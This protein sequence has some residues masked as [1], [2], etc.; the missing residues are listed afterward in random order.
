MQPIQMTKAEYEAKYGAKVPIAVSSSPIQMTR[1]EYEAKYS[2][3]P[4]QAQPQGYSFLDPMQKQ[5]DQMKQEGAEDP[6]VLSGALKYGA[7]RMGDLGVSALKLLNT[8][9]P[10]AYVGQ[11]IAK[12]VLPAGLPANYNP[13]TG[14]QATAGAAQTALAFSGIGTK[15]TGSVLKN[16]GKMGATGY[17]FDVLGNLA[18]GE[19]GAKTLVPGIGTAVGVGLPLVGPLVRGAMKLPGDIKNVVMNK[20]APS[21]EI[22][23]SKVDKQI[24][25]IFKGTTA[26]SAKVAESAFKVKKGLDLL[27]QNAKTLNVADIN[28]PLGSGAT[29]ALNIKKDTPNEIL[30]GVLEM[31]KKIATIGRKAA[32]NATKEGLKL[33]TLSAQKIIADA[34]NQG[35]LSTP[36]TNNLM[37]QLEATQGD[38]TKIHDWIQEQVNIRYFTKAGN[39]E[40]S[41]IAKY[42]NDAADSMRTNL[43]KVVDRAGYAE[44]YGNNQ[45]LKRMLVIIAKKAN[46]KVNFGDIATDAGLDAAI[47]VITGNPEYMARTVATGLFRG[48]L[49]SA[50]NQSGMKSFKK[51]AS[52]LEDIPPN[53]RLPKTNTKIDY[54]LPRLNA[55]PIPMGHA[56]TK[57]SILVTNANADTRTI[58][59]TLRLPAPSERMIIPNTQGTPNILGRP[60]TAGGEPARIG[61]MQQ[62][63]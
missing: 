26:D 52:I 6:N 21:P 44:A 7:G 24:V 57:G 54:T 34:H 48:I 8:D 2:V 18:T 15:L 40:D 53:A 51:A 38:P 60:Y 1:A 50:R 9:K 17:G 22:L 63:M 10:V 5:A 14:V 11:K 23:N 28:A 46:K 43:N 31:D 12:A 16:V 55:G 59:K 42:A 36:A 62:R 49:S 19:T 27:V 61:G 33:D 56:T 47:S 58:N 20:I 45:E 30:S 32:N 13:V 4:T 39:L 29:K 3:A 37:R 35:K 25:N 41:M